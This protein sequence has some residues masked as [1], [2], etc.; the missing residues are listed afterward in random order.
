M[1]VTAISIS[2]M[3]IEV[4]VSFAISSAC[5]AKPPVSASR[6]APSS[7]LE[8]TVAT[9]CTVIEVETVVAVAGSAELAP[10]SILA[11]SL[12]LSCASAA[13]AARLHDPRPSVA[14]I[15]AA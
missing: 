8:P 10:I 1:D 9:D 3:M 4:A 14:A 6:I 2:G 5:L 12:E 15:S 13:P 11:I 7:M